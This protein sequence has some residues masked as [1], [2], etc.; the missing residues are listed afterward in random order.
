MGTFFKITKRKMKFKTILWSVALCATLTGFMSCSDDD[1]AVDDHRVLDL[2]ATWGPA[3][4]GPDPSLKYY[5]DQNAYYWEYT[6]DMTANPNIGLRAEGYYPNAR[7]FNFNVYDD[8]LTYSQLENNSVMDVNITP[9]KGSQN[10][11]TTGATGWNHYTVAFLPD[12]AAA[13]A[14]SKYQNICYFDHTSSHTCIIVRVYL[15]EGEGN[16]GG[17][18][19]PTLTAFDLSTGKDVTLPKRE[20]CN[21]LHQPELPGAAFTSMAPMLFFRAPTS[22]FYPNRPAEYLFCRNKLLADE[23]MMFDFLAPS[24]PKDA[25]EYTSKDMRYWSICIGDNKTLTRVSVIDRDVTLTQPDGKATFVIASA[26]S[27]NLGA[28]RALCAEK[29]YNLLVW[30]RAAW[31]EDLMVLYRNMVFDE[32]YAH[33][34]RKME[35]YIGIGDLNPMKHLANVALGAWGPFGMKVSEAAFLSGKVTVSRQQQQ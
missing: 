15:P 31:D 19:L 35:S 23:V 21:L 4:G 3:L 7:F 16:F 33:S 11:Y 20:D 26:Q 9:D 30:D 18:S 27:Q 28:I 13:S 22:L 1:D 17:V 2:T 32:N 5:P 6:F 25:T 14:K 10:P 34:M 24:F 12:N 8:D 29:Q